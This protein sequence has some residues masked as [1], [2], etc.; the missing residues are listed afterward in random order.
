MAATLLDVNQ[1]ASLNKGRGEY[2]LKLSIS[3]SLRR[4]GKTNPVFEVASMTVSQIGAREE[5]DSA[6]LSVRCGG[7]QPGIICDSLRP[8]S[9]NIATSSLEDIRRIIIS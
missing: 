6:F 8:I 3:D 1:S 7:A 2:T 5:L 4:T 9:R